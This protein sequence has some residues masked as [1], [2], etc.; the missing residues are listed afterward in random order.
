MPHAELQGNS[1][2]YSWNLDDR[3]STSPKVCPNLIRVIPFGFGLI[4]PLGL[5]L[6]LHD[7]G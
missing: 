2:Y 4:N 7:V 3:G 5:E 6:R 1:R